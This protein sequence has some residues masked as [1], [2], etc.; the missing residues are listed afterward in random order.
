MEGTKA[1]THVLYQIPG[2][3][4]AGPLGA[5]ELERRRALLQGWAAADTMVEV[6]DSPGGPHSIESHAEEAA[7]VAPTLAALGRRAHLPDAII[8]GCFS[9]PG[10]AAL[11][12]L[13]DCT[14]IGPFEASFHLAAQLGP[15]VGIVTI[16]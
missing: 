2:D 14:V 8:V 10:L 16:L 12:E 9:D 11:R 7:S 5:A 1:M 13:C 6:A 15:R 4:C 3:M